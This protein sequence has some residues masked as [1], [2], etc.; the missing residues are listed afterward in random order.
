MIVMIQKSKMVEITL[1]EALHQ[2][3]SR[4]HCQYLN[5]NRPIQK[6]I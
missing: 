6:G 5:S 1:Q 2:G 4:S 3:Q